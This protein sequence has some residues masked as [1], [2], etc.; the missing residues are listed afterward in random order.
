M[1][2]MSRSGVTAEDGVDGRYSAT[3]DRIGRRGGTLLVA[4]GVVGLYR[5]LATA[6][7]ALDA[8]SSEF[9]PLVGGGIV[10]VAAAVALVGARGA[11]RGDATFG[12]G[13]VGGTLLGAL[14]VVGLFGRL[15]ALGPGA[16]AVGAVTTLATA[17]MTGTVAV[18][19][20]RGARSPVEALTFGTP[21]AF[22]VFAGPYFAA[23]APETVPVGGTGPAGVLALAAGV[24][25][26]VGVAHGLYRRSLRLTA[27]DDLA[28]VEGGDERGDTGDA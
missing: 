24:V 2:C 28:T 19:T 5:P 14:V 4:A 1:S 10:A 12:A 6:L 13:L 23:F 20:V 11:S 17:A 16:V 7:A 27:V 8:F 21:A 25:L 9:A 22:P 3:R 18:W 26:A 15:T